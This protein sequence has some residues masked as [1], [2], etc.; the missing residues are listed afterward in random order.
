MDR[1]GPWA[2]CSSV[3]SLGGVPVSVSN[4]GGLVAG[5]HAIPGPQGP[6]G[7]GHIVGTGV[8]AGATLNAAIGTTYA[9]QAGTN[10]AW[11]W[12]KQAA[13]N[14]FASWRVIIGDTGWRTIL[15]WT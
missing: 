3:V 6:A 12:Q 4:P 1:F 11:L 9:D 2:R 15:E 14:T 13:P 10:G 8:P 5:T 7:S